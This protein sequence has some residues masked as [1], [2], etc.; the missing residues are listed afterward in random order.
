MPDQIAVHELKQL[1][2]TEI[3]VSDWHAVRQADIT[4][5][6]ATTG[7][8][9]WLHSDIERCARESPFDG[10]TIAQGSYLVS[11]LAILQ[12]EATPP[13]SALRYSL[14][15]GFDRIRFV[16]PVTAGARVRGRFRLR[17]VRDRDASTKVVLLDATIELEG[18]DQPALV[19]EWLGLVAA[20]TLVD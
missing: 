9:D 10:K 18:E 1:V 8:D 7:D 15:Y 12:E 3:G 13:L 16:R 2:G 19:A 6:A 20:E 5:H 14:N 17:D 11:L 4:A